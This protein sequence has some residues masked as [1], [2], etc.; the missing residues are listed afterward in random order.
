MHIGIDVGGTNTDAVLMQGRTPLAGVKQSTSADVTSG[1]VSALAALAQE[2]S[3]EG[4]QIEA[5]MIGTTHFINALIE[6]RRLAPTAAVRLGLPATRALPPLVDWPQTLLEA[7]DGHSYLAHG[8]YEFDGRPIAPLD[9]EELRGI[10]AQIAASGARSVGVS[11]VFSPVNHDLEVEAGRIPG[12][13]TRGRGIHL[14]SPTR[15]DA[16]AC[17]SARTPRSSTRPCANWQ[18]RSW[19]DWRRPCGPKA[20][21]PPSS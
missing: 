14:S 13:G 18:P 20:S 11:S 15:S 7:I 16:S 1:I 19:T 12:R 5:V 9:P 4:D 6:A 3:F 2:H 10:A 8:G 21:K 17:W